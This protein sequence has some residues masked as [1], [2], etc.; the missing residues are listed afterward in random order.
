MS[1]DEQRVMGWLRSQA[2]ELPRSAADEHPDLDTL[3]RHASGELTASRARDVSEHLIVCEDGRCAELV[4]AHAVNRDEVARMLYPED[5]WT[6]ATPGV[7]AR[8]F[9]A[10]D[11]LWD[12]MESLA[13]ERGIAVDEVVSEAM[14]AYAELRGH[15]VAPSDVG[16]TMASPVYARGAPPPAAPARGA[17]L[18]R[19]APP[20]QRPGS[21]RPARAPEPAPRELPRSMMAAPPP[22][23]APNPAWGRPM[24]GGGA[25]LPPPARGAPPPAYGGGLPAPPPPRGRAG[26]PPIP[27]EPPAPAPVPAS[28]RFLSLLFEG[29][30]IPVNRD[31]F[32]IGRSK[33][34]ADYRI[35]DP[36]VSRQHLMIE[37]V[38]DV[39]YV[40]DLGSTNGISV[41]GAKV[42]RRAI[43]DGDVIRVGGHELF[44]ELR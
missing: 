12:T 27:Y 15:S 44:C 35:D 23:S 16:R 34:Q 21:G 37:R 28:T 8:T 11:M 38:Q 18:P 40:V 14:V 36:N 22:V 24:S 10:R 5:E 4:R 31:R 9:Q 43:N 29:D 19:S 2:G 1:A 42:S 33:A 25:P 39:F 32:V 13:R 6:G 20:P 17:G 26:P 41:N 30:R 7:R 3:A